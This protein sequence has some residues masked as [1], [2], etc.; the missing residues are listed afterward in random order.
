M[1]CPQWEKRRTKDS[2]CPSPNVLPRAPQVMQE[3]MRGLLVPGTLGGSPTNF[4]STSPSFGVSFLM[5]IIII[6]TYT[7]I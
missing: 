3:V 6:I 1:C 5:R 7:Y 4:S 2:L